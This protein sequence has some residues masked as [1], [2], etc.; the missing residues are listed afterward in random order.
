MQLCD[1]DL[2]VEL[3]LDAQI[4]RLRPKNEFPHTAGKYV[5]LILDAQLF[6]QLGSPTTL[7]YCR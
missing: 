6:C 3:I 7:P 2:Y 5:E 1:K 4:Y